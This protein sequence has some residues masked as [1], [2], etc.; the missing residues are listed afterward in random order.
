MAGN[1]VITIGRQYGS[2]GREIG[3]R[4]A[5]ELGIKCYERTAVFARNCS[6]IMM[7][8]PQTAFYTP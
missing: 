7:K 1:T 8:S 4:L 5:E 2:G 6:S 3:M